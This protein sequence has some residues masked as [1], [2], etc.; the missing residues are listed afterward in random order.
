[1]QP[2][3]AQRVFSSDNYATAVQRGIHCV[4]KADFFLCMII[5]I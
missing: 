1:M 5:S 4:V 3:D 2:S